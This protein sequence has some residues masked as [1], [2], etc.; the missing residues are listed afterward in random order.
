[1]IVI[2]HAVDGDVAD[3]ALSGIGVLDCARHNWLK[4]N[5]RGLLR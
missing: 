3:C 1:M 2:A 4:R 5:E